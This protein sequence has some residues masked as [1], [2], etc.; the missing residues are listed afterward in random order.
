MRY[1][2]ITAEADVEVDLYDIIEDIGDLY[3]R[4]KDFRKELNRQIQK[5]AGDFSSREVIDIL[6][7]ARKDPIVWDRLKPDLEEMMKED[8]VVVM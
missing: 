3:G 7:V 4:D 2:E 1:I 6:K 5:E 8:Y